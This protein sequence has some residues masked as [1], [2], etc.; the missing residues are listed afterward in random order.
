MDF[1]VLEPEIQ[2][3]QD[4][5]AG[6]QTQGHESRLIPRQTVAALVARRNKALDLWATAYR[7]MAAAKAA[8]VAA[9]KAAREASPGVNSYNWRHRDEKNVF[10]LSA[11]IPERDDYLDTARRLTDIDVWSY[12]IGI[13]NLESLM[14]KEAKDEMRKEL[15]DNPPEVTADN[16]FATI[17][18]F[19]TDADMIFKR[20][21]ANMFSKLDRRFRSHDGWKIGGRV[22]LNGAFDELGSWNYHR[23]H[24][25]TIT[26]IE[27]AFFILDGRKVPESWHGLVYT[28]DEA[29]RK[30]GYNLR[31]RQSEI[32]SE[33]FKIRIY[34]NGNAHVWFKRDDLVRKVNRL[35]GDYYG[36]VIPEE[37][38]PDPDDGLNTPKTTLARHFGFYPSPPRVVADVIEAAMLYKRDGDPPLTVL[39]PSAGTGNLA[40]PAA[41]KGHLVDCCEVQPAYA[42]ALKT[43][44]RY[45]KVWCGDFLGL[46]PGPG[47]Y[48]RVVMNPPFDRERDIDHVMHAL[49][50]LK[51]DGC[52]V[53]VMSA[54]TEF[55]GTRKSEAF[56]ALM[57]R[58]NGKFR[59]LPAG[60]FSEVGT[61]VNTLILK[62]YKS[63]RSHWF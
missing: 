21:V 24:R 20:G 49:K 18:R 55:R 32:D 15:Q 38:E 45:R 35:L 28:I 1:Q 62:V 44:G 4:E 43:S 2:P 25:D 34:K 61:N 29:R 33:F 9:A 52:L 47:L 8:H 13:T 3:D 16:V 42:Q 26:D 46:Q 58:M 14:D 48:D 10:L 36:E 57:E 60:A 51:P 54:G 5:P 11:A 50:F 6:G 22:I 23:N 56:R 31:A 40:L 17:E 12:V 19:V 59:D 63:G 7:T 41:G 37:R 39:E 27:R 30:E 53:A